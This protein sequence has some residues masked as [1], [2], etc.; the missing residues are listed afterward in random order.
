VAGLVLSAAFLA[1]PGGVGLALSAPERLGH[2]VLRSRSA[3]S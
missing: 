3:I 2:L 1:G